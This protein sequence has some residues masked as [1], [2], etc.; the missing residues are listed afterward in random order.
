[1]EYKK[2]GRTDLNISK[3]CLGSM[4]WGA[5]NT[6][7]EGHAQIDMALD[8]GV[9][10]IDT[11]EM[12]PT[13]PLSQETQG[14]TEEIMGAWFAKTG[15]REDVVLATK[16]VGLG[17]GN[18]VGRDG[19]EISP[20]TIRE[21]VEKSL[22][23]LKT[24][25]IDL[26]QFHWP[27]RGSYHFRNH[28]DYDPSTQDKTATRAHMTECLH[29]L[30]DLVT[31]GKIR[32]FGTSNESCWG[33]SQY[34]EIAKAEGL[35]RMASIQNEYSLLCRKYDLDLAELSLNED[36][37]L[38]AYSPL[39]AGI[40]SGKY[41]DGAVPKGSRRAIS[42]DIGGRITPLAQRAVSAYLDVA[43]NH[44]LDPSQMSLAWCA[45]RPFMGSV[46]FGAR[47]P[48]QLEN[49]LKSADLRLSTEVMADIQSAYKNHPSP[50]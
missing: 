33:A 48:P 17:N 16:I 30:N 4:T 45:S 11:A 28:W 10:F 42:P 25:Y 50:L 29:T 38:L 37:G 31:E 2:L 12:Y 47:T 46:I 8:H 34:L 21:A 43:K 6:L 24:D 5:Q 39:A 32:Y 14:R 35:P 44:D 19:A 1:M 23:R 22:I 15:R 9:N 18:V 20:T 41:Q 49:A 26:Y 27:N 3:Y 40:L 36:V 13:P 7:A